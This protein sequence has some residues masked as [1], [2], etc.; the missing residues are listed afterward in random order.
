[1]KVAP[2]CTCSVTLLVVADNKLCIFVLF[3]LNASELLLTLMSAANVFWFYLLYTKE[4]QVIWVRNTLG[5]FLSLF[6]N[7]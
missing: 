2:P 1:M 5:L 4:V 3:P 7:L 6:G